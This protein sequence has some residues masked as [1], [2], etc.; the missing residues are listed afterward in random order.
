ML[1]FT[2]VHN[3]NTH[4]NKLKEGD[5]LFLQTGF[6]LLKNNCHAS[7]VTIDF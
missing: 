5:D 3:T 4:I 7:V 1:K 2:Y 6:A